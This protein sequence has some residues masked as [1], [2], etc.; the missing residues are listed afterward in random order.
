MQCP[1]CNTPL[2]EA[3]VF[4]G[5][6]GAL[7]K[8]Q[9]KSKFAIA[10]SQP[11][12]SAPTV[13][14]RPTSPPV[15]THPQSFGQNNLQ[16]RVSVE[17]D[18]FSDTLTVE[19]E[20][21][22]QPNNISSTY[23]PPAT[24]LVQPPLQSEGKR[25]KQFI[26]L[27]LMVVIAGGVITSA[28]YYLSQKSTSSSSAAPSG[29]VSFFDSQTSIA[30]NTDALRITTASLDD[31]P[32]GYQYNAWLLDTDNEQILSLG[33]LS[34]SDKGF[35]LMYNQDG[36]NLLGQ[37]NQI[38]I[39]QEQQGPS[40]EPLGKPL[41]SAKFPPQVFVH[42]RHLLTKFPDT[43]G[44]IGLLVGL[45]NETQKLYAQA[46]LLQNNLGSGKDQVRQC[47]AQ[48]MID[49]IE[50]KNG[51]DYHTLSDWCTT[52]NIMQTGDGFGLL[53]PGDRPND[54]GYLATAAQ[55]AALTAYL[56]D[57]TSLIRNQ[58]RK[59]EVSTS[60]INNLVQ[61]IK[62]EAMKLLSNP[63]DMSQVTEMVSQS[64]HVYHGFDQN[65]NGII[66]PIMGEAGALTAYTQGQLMATLTLSQ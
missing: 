63:S 23:L 48:S 19:Q 29:Q 11:D 35:V 8:Q 52:Q 25:R 39:T 6:C 32:A 2:E 15:I 60:N 27:F 12:N 45:L 49:I 1:N 5:R 30:G 34:K 26:F 36:T 61:A 65:G 62:K 3:A 64:D 55:H 33:T 31:P 17:R 47:I 40:S 59:V 37:G 21:Y 53:D 20:Q 44:Q 10:N 50:G 58:A 13:V 42:I 51:A 56:S 54:H 46:A 43:P 38:E 14:T 57:T 22:A 18:A 24:P 41:L 16:S 28:I 66:Q 9:L 4:C 7:L